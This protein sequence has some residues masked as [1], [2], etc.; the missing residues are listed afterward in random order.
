MFRF[1]SQL[2]LVALTAVPSLVMLAPSQP[3]APLHAEQK[4]SGSS[5]AA[6][7]R[8]GIDVLEDQNFQPLRGKRVGLVT[9]QTGV[10]SRGR[11]T[12]DALTSA[13]GVKLVA[14]FSPEHGIHAKADGS[15]AD[16][17][18]AATGLRIYSLYGDVRRP[19]EDMLRDLDVLVFDV[20]DA[21]VRFYTYITTMAYCMEAAKAY[22]ISFVVLDRPNPL[23]GQVIEGPTLDPGR[24][25]FTGYYPMPVRY[26]MTLG[27]LALMF[28]SVSHIGADLH[29]VPM[30]GWRRSDTYDQTGLS[31]I[32]PSPNLRTVD[33][34]FIYPG[35]EILQEEGLSVGRGTD[36]PFELLGSP[37]I[38]G[39]KL[40][41]A[42]NRRKIPGVHFAPA[43]F[44]PTEGPNEKKVCHGI[45]IRVSDRATFRSMRTGLEITRALLEMH[46]LASPLRGMSLLGSQSTLDRL[47]HGDAPA[48]IVAG[49]ADDLEK[50]RQIRARYLLYH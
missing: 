13:P 41:A 25:S 2:F 20:Q 36:T 24:T 19:T 14:L 23:A 37:S 34:V 30:E 12:I 42:L 15:V 50:F 16:S 22:G 8:V 33:A 27:E 3:V 38:D 49:W 18:D 46:D 44:T 17:T 35:I 9:N 39:D 5:G 29:V 6:H 31:W 1:R 40:A 43:T 4:I 28:N 11:R 47:N 45:A 21:G 7:V 26:A 10:D 48:V 32:P